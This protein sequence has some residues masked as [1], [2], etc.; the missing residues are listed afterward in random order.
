MAVK[1]IKKL[2]FALLDLTEEGQTGND[3][4]SSTGEGS[5]GLGCRP[6]ASWSRSDKAR[7][8]NSKCH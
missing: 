8:T 7:T 1:C 4:H 3:D 2:I 6:N 5:E